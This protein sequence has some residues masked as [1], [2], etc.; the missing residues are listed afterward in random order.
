M[1]T[2]VL[3]LTCPCHVLRQYL[4]HR[5]R[6]FLLFTLQQ[7]LTQPY[8]QSTPMQEEAPPSKEASPATEMAGARSAN[9]REALELQ[10]EEALRLLAKGT[11]PYTNAHTQT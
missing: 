9:G 11:C 8:T 5:E 7:P 1:R 6:Q 3:T 10:L 2:C 4:D